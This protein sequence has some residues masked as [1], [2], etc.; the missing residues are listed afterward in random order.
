MERELKNIAYPVRRKTLA[1]I[2]KVAK[3][4][5]TGWLLDCGIEHDSTLTISELTLFFERTG[6]PPGYRWAYGNQLKIVA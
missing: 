3:E 2:Y 4:V 6:V 5:I 1:S